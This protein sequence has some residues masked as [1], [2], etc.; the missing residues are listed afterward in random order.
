MLHPGRVAVLYEGGAAAVAAQVEATR[1]LVGGNETDGA[2]WAE[3][4]ARQGAALG[5]ARFA[6][7]DLRAF[8]ASV[9]EAIVRPA[10][11]V[12]YLPTAT[13]DETPEPVRLLQERVRAQFDPAGV[14]A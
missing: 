1:A 7:G 5:R 10:A 14:L 4:M 3:S 2:V 8:L 6:P 12:A 9:P 13:A 11:G